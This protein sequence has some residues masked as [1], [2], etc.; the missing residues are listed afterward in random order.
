MESR[1]EF[2]SIIYTIKQTKHT[3]NA[4]AQMFHRLLSPCPSFPSSSHYFH[5][6]LKEVSPFYVTACA[7]THF[8]LSFIFHNNGCGCDFVGS[9][10]F[11]VAYCTR[12]RTK[13][14][15]AIGFKLLVAL[16]FIAPAIC[17]IHHQINKN[18]KSTPPRRQAST[19]CETPTRTQVHTLFGEGRK[20]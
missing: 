18:K 12:L 8:P 1:E 17:K 3:F 11:L 6:H 19:H 13:E 15:S 14:L 16:E 7:G 20:C 9:Q 2:Y 4:S 5:C 10:H